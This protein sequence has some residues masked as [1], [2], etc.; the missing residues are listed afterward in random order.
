MCLISHIATTRIVGYKV[1]C[2]LLGHGATYDLFD[3]SCLSERRC[4]GVVV[5]TLILKV[6]LVGILMIWGQISGVLGP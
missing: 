6:V 5:V 3:V 1:V 4:G 2:Q